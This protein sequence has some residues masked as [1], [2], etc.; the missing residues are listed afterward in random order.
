MPPPEEQLADDVEE[1]QIIDLPSR[2]ALS[3][4]DPGIFGVGLPQV[5][6]RTPQPPTPVAPDHAT[7]VD[8]K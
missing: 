1:Q 5:I 8:A 2:E 7:S 3:V 4:V 6:P